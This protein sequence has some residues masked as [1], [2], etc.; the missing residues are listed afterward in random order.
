ML[1]TNVVAK[2]KQKFDVHEYLCRLY[3][4]AEMFGGARLATDGNKKGTYNLI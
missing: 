2:S 3:G 1:Q 4:N